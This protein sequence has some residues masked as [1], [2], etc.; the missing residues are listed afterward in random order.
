[1]S[2]NSNLSRLAPKLSAAGDIPV[3]TTSQLGGAFVFPASGTANVGTYIGTDSVLRGRGQGFVLLTSGSDNWT[4]PER[5]T[6]IRATVVGG[7]GAGGGVNA[8]AAAGLKGPGGGGGGGAWAVFY[9]S[10]LPGQLIPYNIGAGGTCL[11]GQSGTAGGNTSFSGS[12]VNGG[13]GG[14]LYAGTETINRGDGGSNPNLL[15][16]QGYSGQGGTGGS[17]A[18][19]ATQGFGGPGGGSLTHAANIYY[20]ARLVTDAIGSPGTGV[21]GGRGAGATA[22]TTNNNSFNGNAASGYGNGGSGAS[23]LTGSTAISN[24]QGGAGSGGAILIEW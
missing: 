6:F 14:A 18:A 11:P 22:A 8:S 5:V 10:V 17:G 20:L 13:G 3:A 24:A 21:I 19:S 7:G 4:V 2:N 1:M 23:I 9:L 15:P 16:S 12:T